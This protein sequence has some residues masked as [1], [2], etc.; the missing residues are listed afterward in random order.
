LAIGDFLYRS[1]ALPFPQKTARL[2]PGG[3]QAR[4]LFV[5]SALPL[6]WGFQ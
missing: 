2:R 1:I 5:R 4:R 6:F 3:L